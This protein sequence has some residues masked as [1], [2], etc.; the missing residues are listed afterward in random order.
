MKSPVLLVALIARAARGDTPVDMATNA[1]THSLA[2][3]D[4]HVRPSS[5]PHRQLRE[6]E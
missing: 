1:T 2:T 3:V 4:P 6:V 5:A